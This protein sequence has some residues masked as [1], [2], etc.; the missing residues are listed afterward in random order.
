MK[1]NKFNSKDYIIVKGARENNLKNMDINIPKNKL[2]VITGLSGS[3]KSSL[4]FDTIYAEGQRRYLESL[5]SYARQFLGG[6]EKPD[7]DSIEGL[8]P[9]ISIEQKTTSNNPRST[10]GTTTEIYDYFRLVFARVGKPFCPKGHGEIKTLTIQ[11]I[12][13][14]IFKM[15]EG[16]KLQ[17]LA[18]IIRSEKGTFQNKFKELLHLGYLRV[19]VNGEYYSL[20]DE[21]ILEKNK[22][23][24]IDIVIDRVII[25]DDLITKSRVYEGIEKATNETKGSVCLVFDN[26]EEIL[27]LNHSCNKCSFSIPELEPRLFSF[28]SP[29]GACNDCNGLGFKYEPDVSKLIPDANLSINDGAIEYFKNTQETSSIDWQRF[30]ALLKHFKID[31]NK[32]II[33]FT[34]KELDHIL[35]ESE[36]KIEIKIRTVSGSL[37]NAFE[38]A[39]GVYSLIQRRHMNTTSE[40]SREYY[41]KYMSNVQCPRCLGKRL[42]ENALCVKLNKKDIIDVTEYTIDKCLDLFLN[43]ELSKEDTQIVNLALNEVTNRL[44]FLIDVGLNYLTLSRTAST[45]SGGESQRIR[46]ATQIGSS[47]TGVLYVLDEPSIGLHQKDNN[48][49]IDTLKKMRDLGNTLIVVEHDEDTMRLA[50]YLIDIGPGAGQFGG[51]I[52]SHG[53]PSQVEKDSK[54]LTGQYLSKK[55]SIP[56]PKNIRTGNGKSLTLTGA[57]GHNLKNVNL[58]IPLN[59]LIAITGVSG[60]GKSTLINETLVKAIE[61]EISN[62]FITPLKYKTIQGINNIDKVIKI[63]Q[64]PIG[65]TPRSNPATYVTVFDD[66]R[67]IFTNT[68]LSKE[69]G[70]KKGRFSF[71]VKGGRCENCQGDGVK[72]IE[73]HFLPDVYIKCVECNGKKYNSETLSILW[74]GKSIYDILE[75]SV[76]SAIDFFQSVAQI[77]RKLQLMQDVG[78]GYIKLGE[79]ATKLSGGEAQRIKIA[80]F[81]QKKATGKTLYVLDEPTTGLHIHDVSLLIKVLNRI[82]DNGDTVIVIE[83]NL[84][85]IK[86]AD[87]IVDIGPDGG[88]GG[89]E[90]VAEGTLK[91]IIDNKKSYTG[92]FLSKII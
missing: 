37:Y 78:L 32:K 70:Y 72:K 9:A 24:D 83:H 42:S 21:I 15:P 6:N 1:E 8:S 53:T 48:R 2:V 22:K 51:Q 64:D 67:D 73:M 58:K 26:E 90:I 5:S 80:K 30:E 54:S 38:H 63:S 68:K 3:G 60:S 14:R 4:A 43:L 45:L 25:N 82:V 40:L 20:D 50:D 79:Q 59:K 16:T 19:R 57:S 49:L 77:K 86:V 69:R 35:Y 10:V 44:S 56:I 71:N 29:I 46:L 91:D 52:V 75:M 28:N 31:K 18:P 92:E 11:S 81:L 55:K 76:D 23:H 65:R 66:I 41:S 47:L 88:N 85:L 39:E 27:S 84:E 87:Y 36:E 17:I 61:K 89:G 34:K 74:K 12:Q 13:E 33:D 7:V 62:P